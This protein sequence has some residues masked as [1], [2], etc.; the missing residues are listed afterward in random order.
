[1][2]VTIK[3]VYAITS[4]KPGRATPART[5]ELMLGHWQVETLHH[6]RDVTYAEDAARAAEPHPAPWPPFRNLAIG[7]IGAIGWSN[8]AEATE[9]YRA[10]PA[11]ALQ[12]FGSTM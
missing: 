1:M 10:N 4:I 6:I 9:H 12:W 5:G 2:K 11:H 8:V 7:L 3:T